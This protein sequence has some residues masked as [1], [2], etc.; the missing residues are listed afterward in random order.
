M[1]STLTNPDISGS[2][3][4]TL[5]SVKEKLPI[6][7]FSFRDIIL[8]LVEHVMKT[9]EEHLSNRVKVGDRTQSI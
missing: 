5:L 9:D 2:S 4:S 1:E 3:T 6:P 7:D 8:E